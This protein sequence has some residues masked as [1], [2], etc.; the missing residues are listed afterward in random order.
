ML[1]LERALACTQGSSPMLGDTSTR[2]PLAQFIRPLGYLRLAILLLPQSLT[3]M[4]HFLPPL[5]AVIPAGIGLVAGAIRR[6][7]LR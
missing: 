1:G 4:V 3:V 2:E 7:K 5:A 6:G